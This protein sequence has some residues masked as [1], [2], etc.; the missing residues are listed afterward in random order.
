MA[1]KEPAITFPNADCIPAAIEPP[2]IPAVPKPIIIGAADI[3]HTAAPVA[4]IPIPTFLR[5]YWA[6]FNLASF[7]LINKDFS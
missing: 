4:A 1:N 6:N 3:T 2:T 7:N 5:W